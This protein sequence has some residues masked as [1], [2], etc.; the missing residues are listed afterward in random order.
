[1]GQSSNDTRRELAALYK[2][3]STD[4]QLDRSLVGELRC[5]ICELQLGHVNSSTRHALIIWTI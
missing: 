5:I 1:M 4:D 2:Q 3:K